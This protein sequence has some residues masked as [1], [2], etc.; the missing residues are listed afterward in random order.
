MGIIGKAIDLAGDWGKKVASNLS[1]EGGIEGLSKT[2]LMKKG[3]SIRAADEA[4]KIA[5]SKAGR[6]V[7]EEILE[8]A[9]KTAS[10]RKSY[11]SAVR[12]ANLGVIS[13]AEAGRLQHVANGAGDMSSTL[14][15][16]KDLAKEYFTGGTKTQNYTRR[17]AAAGAYM[18][19]NIAGRAVTGGS[20]GY[21][22]KGERDIA[23]IPMI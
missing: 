21:N 19:V 6:E 10:A 17:A 9:G 22:N 1:V 8:T 4:A 11:N 12:I 13:Y 7:S 2:N 3:V 15:S 16:G 14:L 5:V 18:G 20:L 23:G